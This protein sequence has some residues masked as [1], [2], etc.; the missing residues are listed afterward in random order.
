MKY[1]LLILLFILLFGSQH[2]NGQGEKQELITGSFNTLTI[3]QFVQKIESQVNSIFYVDPALPDSFKIYLNVENQPLSRV[4][5]LAFENSMIKY[6]FDQERHVFLTKDRKVETV[7]PAGF[8]REYL[9]EKIPKE[10]VKSEDQPFK[11]SES[12]RTSNENQVIEIGFKSREKPNGKAIISGYVHNSKTGEPLPGVLVYPEEKGIG[13][14]SDQFGY[15]SLPLTLGSHSIYYT[16]MGMKDAKRAVKLL[17]DGRLNI[18]MNEKVI[19]LKG[20][21]VISERG[22]NLR[23]LQM[24]AI[25]LTAQSI[26]Q[27]PTL[28]GEKDILKITLS[29][30]GVK[31][32]GEGSAGFNV[33]GGSSDQNLILFNNG[34]IYNPA[35]LFGFFSAINSDVVKDIQ[36][37]KSG[38]PPK[39]GGRLSSLLEITSRDGNVNKF[40]GTAG[41]GLV[42]SHFTIEGPL[43]KGKT[44]Y[45]IGG[46]TTYSDWLLRQ[47]P[48]NSG[49]TN[50]SASFYDVNVNITH[51]FN[52][53]NS[54]YFTGYLS[55]DRFSLSKDT[56]Y[57]YED[58]SISLKWR[59]LFSNKFSGV[60]VTGNDFYK[61]GTSMNSN[62][63]D[64]YKFSFNIDQI[65]LKAD[66]NY[67]SNSSSSLNFGLNTIHYQ[68]HPGTYLP[69]S[70]Q[71]LVMPD[72]VRKEQAMESALYANE[73][74]DINSRLAVNAGIRYS[75]FNLLGPSKIYSYRSNMPMTM[76]NVLDSLYTKPGAIAKTYQGP[77]YRLSIRYSFPSNMS[78]KASYNTLRQYIH[79]I[80]NT[81]AMSPSDIWKLSDPNIKPQL[82]DQYSLGVYKNFVS[83]TIEA[84]VEVYYKN[85]QNYLD[86]KSGAMLLMNHHLETEVFT[87]KGMAYGAEF[88]VKKAN[89]KLNG[90]LS[91]TYSRTFIKMD[92]SNAGEIINGGAYYPANYDVPH[93]FSLVGNYKFSHRYSVSLNGV[94]S[95]GRPITLPIGKFYYNGEF[96]PLYSSRN[97]YRVPDYFR[98]DLSFNL[99]GNHVVKQLIH[100][101]WTFGVYN[102]TAR[103]NPYSIYFITNSTGQV[104]GY[105]LSILG[106]AIPFITYNIRF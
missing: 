90:W 32:V 27:V 82:G 47:L 56:L 70:S 11:E 41:I 59:H 28:F 104:Q 67:Y 66:F 55:S 38:I 23:Q 42:T 30:P 88:M 65:Y 50:G 63:A 89:G 1:N 37:Y 46:R 5:E 102:L 57:N 36:F 58:K 29:L 15:Y 49:Y 87:T 96:R 95:T 97:A 73:E 91:Y 12:I 94:Y 77:E 79:M 10:A 21:E 20:V 16:Y 51:Q 84:S 18:E 61:S 103:K 45:L 4:L 39:F 81:T 69:F 78:V 17:S 43:L 80:S 75:L 8:F 54:L 52:S 44:S 93:D 13:V 99:E 6:A 53:Q 76:D 105:K 98:M 3:R 14:V 26:K 62:P 34:T 40:T 100:G 19:A 83:N 33:R 64:G 2:I 25:K 31:S 48:K 74:F 92:D 60:F 101:S 106:T 68:L 22:S 9:S 85:I 86:Y 7:L 71:S 35:H 24:G 72:V